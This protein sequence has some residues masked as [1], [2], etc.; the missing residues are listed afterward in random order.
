MAVP[1]TPWPCPRGQP[2]WPCAHPR[3]EAQSTV[4]LSFQLSLRSRRVSCAVTLMDTDFATDVSVQ[5]RMQMGRNTRSRAR[6]AGVDGDPAAEVSPSK[7]LDIFFVSAC[8]HPLVLALN[9][10]EYPQ[11]PKKALSDPTVFSR[12]SAPTLKSPML[13]R[14]VHFQHLRGA[15]LYICS[16]RFRGAFTLERLHYVLSSIWPRFERRSTSSTGPPAVS[17]IAFFDHFPKF[18]FQF[19]CHCSYAFIETL[20]SDF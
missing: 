1:T 17:G 20:I 5:G 3:L 18:P 6:H 8:R 10:W 15:F 19:W 9:F 11:V 2:P 7:P 14:K 4:V 16:L 12:L 13:I